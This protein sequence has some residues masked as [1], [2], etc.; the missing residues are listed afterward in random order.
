VGLLLVGVT[1][2][3]A[4]VAMNSLAGRA[5]AVAA[6]PVITR[7]HGVFSASVVAATLGTGL[8]AAL[9]LP[10]AVPFVA[11]AVLAL[12]IGAGLP[13]WVGPVRPVHAGPAPAVT[14]VTGRLVLAPLLLVGALGALAFAGENAHQSWSA[15][16]ARDELGTSTGLAAVAPAVFAGTAALTRFALGGIPTRHARTV[17]TL[18]GAAAAVGALVFSAAVDLAVATAGL[19][20][21]AAGAAVLFPTLLGIVSRDVVETHR[22]RATST[23]TTVAYLGFLLGPVYVGLWA[24]GVGLRGAMVAVAVLSVLFTALVPALLRTGGSPRRSPAVDDRGPRALSRCTGG[25]S[26]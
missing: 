24:D 8:T 16:F 23:V 5:E 9:G 15:V 3:A 19:V 14:T 20:L 7:A 13:R 11:V 12:L 1:S 26:V 2:G 10:V 22:G 18:G 6:R 21:A 17:L 25:S 4:D